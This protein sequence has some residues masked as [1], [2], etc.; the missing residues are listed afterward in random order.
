MRAAHQLDQ[1]F[2]GG[3]EFTIAELNAGNGEDWDGTIYR[4]ALQGLTSGAREAPPLLK[5]IHDLQGT[6]SCQAHSFPH[7]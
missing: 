6:S 3:V 5:D 2:L 1:A 4:E 7:R